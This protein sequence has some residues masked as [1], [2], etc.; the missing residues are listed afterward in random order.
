[1]EMTAT[2]R[3]I[4]FWVGKQSLRVWTIEHLRCL[5]GWRPDGGAYHLVPSPP[6]PIHLY[7]FL[8]FL[9]S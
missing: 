8:L 1:M 4:I 9:K 2:W 6:I 5:T 7:S 3:I